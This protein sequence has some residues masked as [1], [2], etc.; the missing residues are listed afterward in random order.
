MTPECVQFLQDQLATDP[1]LTLRQ[2]ADVLGTSLQMT[3]CP[4]SV[5]NHLDVS[6][7]TM[8]QFHKEPQYMN[9][10]QNKLKRREY[11]IKLQR[12]QAA[13]TTIIYMDETNFNLWS[14]RIRGRSR[15]GH[16]AVKKV[17]AGGG[18]NLQVI[19]CIGI[20]GVV[21]YEL[22]YGGNKYL[23]S[24]EFIR[25]TLHKFNHLS[26]IV[27]VKDKTSMTVAMLRTVVTD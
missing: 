17:F 16:R 13:G 23:Q 5:K 11:L 24:N 7:I 1:D 8:K 25:A 27:L 20:G 6:L 21:H 2:L 4:Q 12:H 18:Q 19:A 10:P 15:R 22:R 3:V 9:T 26:N 14:T